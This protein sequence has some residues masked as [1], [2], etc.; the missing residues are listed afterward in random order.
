MMMS[1]K[2]GGLMAGALSLPLLSLALAHA[3]QS[4][5]LLAALPMDGWQAEDVAVSNA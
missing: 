5:R 4:A 1:V 2:F 3:A